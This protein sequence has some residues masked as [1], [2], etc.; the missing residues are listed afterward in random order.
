MRDRDEGKGHFTDFHTDCLDDADEVKKLFKG[1]DDSSDGRKRTRQINPKQ[2]KLLD[3]IKYFNDTYVINDTR[4]F[5]V[6]SILGSIVAVTIFI[7]FLIVITKLGKPIFGYIKEANAIK[8]TIS[9]DDFKLN[10]NIHIYDK[11]DDEILS[12][13]QEKNIEYL[14]YEQ[15]PEDVFN[16]F[17]AVEDKRFYKHNGIDI[18]SLIRAGVSILKNDGAITQGGSTITQQLVK[19]TYLSTEQSI[20][21]KIKE[22]VIAFELE[23]TFSKKEILEYYV[24]NIYFG[25]NAYGINSASLEYFGKPVTELSLAQICYLAAIPNNPTIYD[26][27]TKDDTGVNPNTVERQILFLDMMLE[28]KFITK[29]EYDIAKA[30]KIELDSSESTSGYDIRKNI[31][32]EEVAEILMKEDGFKLKY[33]FTSDNDRKVYEQEYNEAKK[34]ALAKLYKNGY[35]VY[36]SFDEA[37]Q[38]ETQTIID[39][40]LSGNTETTDEGIYALQ[41]ST[42]LMNNETGLIEAIIGGRTSPVTDY[43]NRATGLQRQNGSTMKPIA[44]YAPAIEINGLLPTTIVDDTKEDD[45]PKNAGSYMGKITARQALQY[46]SNAVAYKLFREVKPQVGLSF[47]Q[48]MEFKNIVDSDYNLASGLGGLTIGTN[49]KEMAGA[50]ATLAN[51]GKF[52]RPSCVRE[53][54][55]KDG[56]VVYSHNKTNTEIYSEATAIIITDMMK[57][58]VDAGTGTSA[59]F[60]NTIDIA[61]KTGTTDDDKD[62]WFAGYTPLYTAVVWTGYDNP[63]SIQGVSAGK[64]WNKIMSNAHKGLSNLKF[65]E[66]ENIVKHVWVNSQGKEVPEGTEGAIYEIFP[67]DYEIEQDASAL[68]ES[69]KKDFIKKLENNMIDPNSNPNDKI[70]INTALSNLDIFENELNGLTIDESYKTQI[71]GLI[72]YDREQLKARLKKIEEQSNSQQD[73]TISTD[74][75][76]KPSNDKNNNNTNNNNSNNSNSGNTDNKDESDNSSEENVDKPKE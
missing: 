30:E 35:S 46:S 28:N 29:E 70:I 20:E 42:I 22:I 27:Y 9:V 55:D 25:N 71:L 3:K 51:K 19:L 21:R 36:T 13:N 31:V 52:N 33:K 26:P 45:G 75:N 43:N 38:R 63:K 54:R 64:I 58:V 65:D 14:T 74:K 16:A 44:V 66:G 62:L 61:G 50:Y 37:L 60:N 57:T 49:V 6:L 32:L 53:I 47:L 12:V 15:I 59:K 23:D 73:I 39:E 1:D 48:N 8:K 56:N 2:Q 5:K 18:K 17:I 11:N 4:L 68:A 10:S 40:A 24:N 34:S 41:A 76:N 72:N 69:V 67:Y 7:C